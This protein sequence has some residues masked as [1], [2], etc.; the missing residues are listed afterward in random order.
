MNTGPTYHDV[1]ASVE[2]SLEQVASRSCLP[3]VR[4]RTVT[5]PSEDSSRRCDE[6]TDQSFAWRGSFP[7]GRWVAR[8]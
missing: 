7:S 6:V 4:V 8:R 3:R 2:V 1:S 5:L